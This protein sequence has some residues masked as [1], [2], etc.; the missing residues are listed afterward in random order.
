MTDTQPTG[1]ILIDKPAGFT[2]H[3][4][5]A[6]LRRITGIRKIGHAGTLDPFA[7]GLL[8]VGVGRA[9]TRQLGE[10]TGHDK[11]YEAKAVL[12]ATS[13]TQDLT[14]E[15]TGDPVE[16][17]PSPET[18]DLVLPGFRGEIEQIPPMYSAKKIKGKK[19]Y[20][21]ARAGEEVERKPNQVTIH[22]LEIRSYQPPHLIFR[23][24]CS[25]GTYIRTLAHD[26]GQAL[27]IGAYLETLRRT[28]SG[29]YSVEQ[30]VQLD[31]LTPE[32]WSE[33]L[34]T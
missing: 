25:A 10:L 24:R 21:L 22:E 31:Q 5:V 33:H 15:L 20:E 30:A 8:V 19:L 7:T 26:I 16:N 9:A 17:W 3:D 28:K 2:S 11:E 6:K 32:N 29:D 14:G 4:V 1:F 12:G 23:A 34:V 18:L 13:D 27:G